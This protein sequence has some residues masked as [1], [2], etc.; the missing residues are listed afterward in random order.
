MA[1]NATHRNK[2][3]N[4]PVLALFTGTGYRYMFQHTLRIITTA[5]LIKYAQQDTKPLKKKDY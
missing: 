1:V 2:Q 4:N 5:T 3:I